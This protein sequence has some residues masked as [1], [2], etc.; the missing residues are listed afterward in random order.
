M[1]STCPECQDSTCQHLYV[2]V[3]STFN[4]TLAFWVSDTGILVS[5]PPPVSALHVPA[6]VDHPGLMLIIL[7]TVLTPCNSSVPEGVDTAPACRQPITSSAQPFKSL[8]AGFIYLPSLPH[9]PSF[10]N[11]MS[12][13]EVFWVVPNNQDQD[14]QQAHKPAYFSL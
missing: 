13:E 14:I 1:L 8:P 3:A 4:Q 2:V 7:G 12:S 6:A 5:P 9:H 10:T 11:L